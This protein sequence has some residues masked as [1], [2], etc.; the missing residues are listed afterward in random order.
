MWFSHF[1]EYRGR[2]GFDSYVLAC[3]K[4][5]NAVWSH[6][7]VKIAK[8]NFICFFLTLQLVTSISW[9]VERRFRTYFILFTVIGV[10]I[11]K[12]R[13]GERFI[14]QTK[15]QRLQFRHH[16]EKFSSSKILGKTIFEHYN[17][18]WSGFVFIIP[19]KNSYIQIKIARVVYFKG[20][21][22]PLLST[23]L[24]E[25]ENYWGK[26]VLSN[27]LVKD[28]FCYVACTK[29]SRLLLSFRDNSKLLK[30][31]EQNNVLYVF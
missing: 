18:V 14:E 29:S 9:A 17:N 20:V 6:P 7:V 26:W 15:L 4:P 10:N 28:I 5:A 24:I 3:F 16:P 30:P 1:L 21:I 22:P 2:Q 27:F 13:L 12:P 19:F 11:T 31:P 8:K 23:K 25:I